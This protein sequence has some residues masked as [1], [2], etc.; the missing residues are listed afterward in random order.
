MAVV[1]TRPEIIKMA[2]VIRA[3]RR[4]AIPVD[5]V[6]CGQHY[7][8]NMSQQFITELQLQSPDY[9]YKVKAC[10]QGVQ[11]AQILT[12]MERLMKTTSPKLVLVEGDTNGV[13]GT[14]LAAVKLGI[15]VGHVESGLRSFDLRM[16]EDVCAHNSG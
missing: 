16:P 11:T 13:L 5:F 4:N 12:H 6:H 1:G 3:L 15:P 10:S 7:D 2:P 9:S 8:H 14:A